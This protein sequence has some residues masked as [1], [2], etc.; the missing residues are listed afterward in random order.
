V[1]SNHESQKYFMIG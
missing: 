1:T